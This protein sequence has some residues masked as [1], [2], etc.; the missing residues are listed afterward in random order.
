MFRNLVTN[1]Y[2]PGFDYRTRFTFQTVYYVTD[3]SY[4]CCL[5]AFQHEFVDYVA[6]NGEI[7]EEVY[8]KIV[9]CVVDG[10]CHHVS[11]KIQEKRRRQTSISAVHIMTAVGTGQDEIAAAIAQTDAERDMYMHLFSKETFST[12]L[13]QIAL[14]KKKFHSVKF[15]YQN[16]IEYNCPF[17][18]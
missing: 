13:H 8:E 9:K 5:C 6:E 2:M 7:N 14:I 16:V 1:Q 15:H 10:K 3:Y 17:Y 11:D 4:C 12:K 18:Y